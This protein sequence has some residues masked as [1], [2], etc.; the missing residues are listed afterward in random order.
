MTMEN[1]KDV[2]QKIFTIIIAVGGVL[3][4]LILV[5]AGYA[6]F[7]GASIVGVAEATATAAVT[8]FDEYAADTP[9][10]AQTPTEEV[11]SSNIA[12]HVTPIANQE[13]L[14]KEILE[15]EVVP[16]NDLL[17]LAIRFDDISDPRVQLKE[18]PAVKENGQQ[19][20]FWILNVDEN[21]YRQI[22]ATLAY[23]TDHLYFW[24]EK[25]VDYDINDITQLCEA[26]E[27]VIYPN[28][29]ELFGSEWSPGVDNDEHLVIVFAHDLGGASG[30]FSGTD[31][32]M[33]EVKPYS[34]AA[35]MFYLSADFTDPASSFTYGVLA[36]EFQHMIHWHQDRNETSWLNEGLS[37]L[38]VDINGFDIGGFDYLFAFNPDLQLTF[39]PGNDQ[40]DSSPHYGASY[41]FA[42][43]LLSQFGSQ[44]ISEL[45]QE[46]KDGMASVDAML[47]KYK[48]EFKAED[49]VRLADQVFQ[50]WTI[51][52]YILNNN[53]EDG[54]YGYG[55]DAVI[56]AFAQSEPITCDSGWRT[57]TVS[58]YGTDYIPFDCQG[59]FKIEIEAADTVRLLEIGPHSGETYFWSNIG[60]ESHMR[61]SREFDLTNVDGP[62]S[63]N[64]W[65]WFDIERDYD[66][67]YLS[68]SIDGE[69][70]TMLEPSSCTSDDPTGANYGC[71]YNGESDGWINEVVDLSDFAGEKVTLQFDYLTD[72]AVN[73]DGM[74]LDDV[75]IDAIDYFTD[76]EADDGGW[77]GEGFVRVTNELPQSFAV[78]LIKN[79]SEPQVEKWISAAGL[80]QIIEVEN[81][82]SQSAIT[83][84][85]SGLTR[86]THLDAF[87]KI[88]VSSTD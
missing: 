35:E 24:V 29:R 87:Y 69:T 22:T 42:K 33:P 74:L 8:E 67:A 4:G 2:T 27:N 37:E 80:H 21:S 86:T 5:F 34:N 81:N 15:A 63:L 41:L 20:Q 70:W 43:Y 47:E 28:D 60:D 78:T 39:W 38:A 3:V 6:Y 30:Y 59:N 82:D 54:V 68:A 1:K 85:I 76:F 88:N 25:N 56:P 49:D 73:G 62:I 65:T 58:Q 19:E 13:F 18:P 17:D 12:V 66:Y 32:I 9:A 36:H 57:L 23:Q 10:A 44:A 31:S 83:L 61:L 45:V 79:G 48:D 64:Y 72:A 26:F 16:E 11:I 52:N 77:S 7:S 75:S 53:M 51:A 46:P 50:N 55:P 40:G 14:T 84:A 71:G